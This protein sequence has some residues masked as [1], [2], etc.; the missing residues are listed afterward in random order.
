MGKKH[1]ISKFY[2]DRFNKFSCPLQM[3]FWHYSP[4]GCCIYIDS[5]TGSIHHLYFKETCTLTR[6]RRTVQQLLTRSS[7]SSSYSWYVHNDDDNVDIYDN[8]LHACNGSND[9]DG[10]FLKV[11]LQPYLNNNS[12]NGVMN[13]TDQRI[14]DNMSYAVKN[15]VLNF[16]DE[17]ISQYWFITCDLNIVNDCTL[18]NI[19]ESLVHDQVIRNIFGPLVFCAS[20]ETLSLFFGSVTNRFIHDQMPILNNMSVDQLLCKLEENIKFI[21]KYPAFNMIQY[22]PV[23]NMLYM[24]AR[25]LFDVV[26]TGHARNLTNMRYVHITNESNFLDTWRRILFNFV[27]ELSNLH[28]FESQ[29]VRI[30]SSCDAVHFMKGNNKTVIPEFRCESD[31]EDTCIHLKTRRKEYQIMSS[32][33]AIDVTNSS[34]TDVENYTIALSDDG[35]IC[36]FVLK[37]MVE[38]Y[39]LA[40]VDEKLN[41]VCFFNNTQFEHKNTNMWERVIN[42]TLHIDSGGAATSDLSSTLA[43]K[44]IAC[45]QKLC[46]SKRMNDIHRFCLPKRFLTLAWFKWACKELKIN[47]FDFN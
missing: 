25:D 40:A 6:D 20:I 31:R 30:K 9:N 2:Y 16:N 18:R 34:M 26:H 1:F 43:R 8:N 29:S 24:D 37:V 15:K 28:N 7:S 27:Q 3:G 22:H 36:R 44:R 33:R 32:H 11:E 5:K 39:G 42:E 45:M 23:N 46:N 13:F 19:S 41:F 4:N 35:V 21:T 38:E 47:V 17:T 10:R 12:N 14:L